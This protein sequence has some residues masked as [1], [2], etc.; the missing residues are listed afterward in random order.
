VSARSRDI[1]RV[2]V[3]IVVFI[4]LGLIAG[5]VALG[6]FAS[7]GTGVVLDLGLGVGGAALVGSLFEHIAARSPAGLNTASALV[8]ALAGAAALLATFHGVRDTRYRRG[9][10]N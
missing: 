2:L 4:S 1:L 8:A 5:Y 7:T 6:L 3:S 9:D 10:P